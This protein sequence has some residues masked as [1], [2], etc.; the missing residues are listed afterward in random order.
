[1][2]NA[3][4]GIHTTVSKPSATTLATNNH[5]QKPGGVLY[6]CNHRT[7]LDP[8]FISYALKKPVTAVTYSMSRFS[9]V[10][11]PINLAR[12]T[13]HREKDRALMEQHLAKGDLVV[14]PEGTTCREPYLL[15]FSPL[16]AEL[17][18]EI[19]PAAVDFQVNMFHGTTASG[20]KCLDPFFNLLNPYIMVTVKI[21]EKIPST[22][23]CTAGGKTRVEVANHVQKEIAKALK[24]DTT[25]LTRKEKYII[26]AGNE[27]IV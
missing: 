6:V 7:L 13:R 4:T 9:E 27:G 22:M 12:L 15:R 20:I 17:T 11:S 10:S 14:C 2:L 26:L 5:V 3:S 19:V 18:D 1:M 16:F 23:T 8:I 25:N 21:L 24:F